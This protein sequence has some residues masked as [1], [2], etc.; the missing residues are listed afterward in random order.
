MST[1]W[2]SVPGYYHWKNV[3]RVTNSLRFPNNS[4][5]IAL[6]RFQK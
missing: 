1:P 3:F 6:A 5:E 4:T 2:N